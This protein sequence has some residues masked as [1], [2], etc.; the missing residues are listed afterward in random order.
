[1][2]SDNSIWIKQLYVDN[3]HIHFDNNVEL[4]TTNDGDLVTTTQDGKEKIIGAAGAQGIQGL[5]GDSGAAGAA[6][7][8]GAQGIQGIQGDTGAQGLKGATGA[9]G[10]VGAQ[11]IQGIQGDSGVGTVIYGNVYPYPISSYNNSLS[12]SSKTYFVT[13]IMPSNFTLSKMCIYYP[14]VGSDNSSVAIYKGSLITGELQ[15]KSTSTNST[16]NY[17]VKTVTVIDGF[18]S[19]KF[20][21]GDQV[22]IAFMISGSGTTVAYQNTG[23]LDINLAF[24][25]DTNGTGAGALGNVFPDNLTNNS[26][27]IANRKTTSARICMDLQ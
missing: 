2:S 21:T 19:L 24:S 3:H 27:L 20:V 15:G 22:V 11:G 6:G 16:S 9:A 8:V 5:K 17:F 10:A 26:I 7:A 23:I 1:M 13:F 25:V 4:K 12:P 14:S 18:K